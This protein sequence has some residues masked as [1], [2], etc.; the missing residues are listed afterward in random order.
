[1]LKKKK[2]NQ[3]AQKILLKEEAKYEPGEKTKKE[4]GGQMNETFN[5]QTQRRCLY[6]TKMWTF[7]SYF[8]QDS[9]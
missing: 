3:L 2:L 8:Y 5:C 7:L 6:F 4:V 1:M 9:L